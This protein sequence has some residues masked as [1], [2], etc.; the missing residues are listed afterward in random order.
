MVHITRF[1]ANGVPCQKP[2]QLRVIAPMP[3]QVTDTVL[4]TA[5]AHPLCLPRFLCTGRRN[6]RLFA[7]RR[8]GA[9]HVRDVKELPV[10][11]PDWWA[12][13]EEKWAADCP[14]VFTGNRQRW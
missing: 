6:R 4:V 14:M 11:V 13:C 1:R 5:M 10:I 9:K 7:S 2:P 12:E 8:R 3:S